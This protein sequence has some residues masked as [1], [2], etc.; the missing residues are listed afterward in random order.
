M[1]IT[2]EKEPVVQPMYLKNM[3]YNKL[4]LLIAAN[5]TGNDHL[6]KIVIKVYNNRMLLLSSTKSTW[7]NL[8]FLDSRGWRVME[9]EKGTVVSLTQE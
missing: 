2:V 4:Y 9:L 8:D 5:E 1:K 7:D 6:G 3:E